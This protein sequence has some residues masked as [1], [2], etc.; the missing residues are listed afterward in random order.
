MTSTA[1]GRVLRWLPDGRSLAYIVTR[2]GVS[3]IWSMPI[4]GGAPKQLTNF[5]TDQIAWFD[6]SR[7]GK[8]TLFSR[9]YTTRD[10]VLISGFRKL[11][12][13]GLLCVARI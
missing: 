2:D 11:G 6:L 13:S 9:G 8:P 3:N 4:D 5:T 7:D 12:A 10:V 1:E